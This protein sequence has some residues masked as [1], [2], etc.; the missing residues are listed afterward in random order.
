MRNIFWFHFLK[1]KKYFQLILPPSKVD[2]ELQ[3][4]SFEFIAEKDL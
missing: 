2:V 4:K 1:T 3:T